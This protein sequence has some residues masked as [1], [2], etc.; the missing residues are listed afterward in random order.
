MGEFRE[1]LGRQAHVAIGSW[2]CGNVGTWGV[3]ARQSRLGGLIGKKCCEGTLNVPAGDPG[4]A[5]CTP[6]S[7]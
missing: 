2:L 7:A 6:R 5:S 4:A 3:S 1:M